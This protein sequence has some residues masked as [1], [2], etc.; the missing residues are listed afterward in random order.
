[1]KNKI[2]TVICSFV[3]ALSLCSCKE[4]P[5]VEETMISKRAEIVYAYVATQARTSARGEVTGHNNYL[6]YGVV[7]GENISNEEDD[8]N[9]LTIRQSEEDYSYI[10]Y[11]FRHWVY[12]DGGTFDRYKSCAVYLTKDMLANLNAN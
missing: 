1:M 5:V 12:A 8:I 10:E 4:N 11:Y 6:C 7:D 9:H 2:I 3:L